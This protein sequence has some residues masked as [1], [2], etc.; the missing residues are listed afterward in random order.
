MTGRLFED[1]DAPLDWEI[2]ADAD[3]TIARIVFSQPPDDVFDYVVPE[4]LREL[5]QPGQRVKVPLGRGNRLVTGYCVDVT[6]QPETSRRLKEI[7]ELR[8]RRPLLTREM[9]DLTRWIADRYLCTWGQV[10]ES[11][12]PAGVKK[13]AGT[14]EIVCYQF[15]PNGALERPPTKLPKKQQAVLDVLATMMSRCPSAS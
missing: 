8:D 14:R 3:R 10:L 12:I 5:I 6:S 4:P 1:D 15:I 9:L 11:V 13:Q 2:A 7:A